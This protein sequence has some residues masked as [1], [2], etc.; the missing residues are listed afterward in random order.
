MCK[1]FICGVMNFAIYECDDLYS[2]VMS[3][4]YCLGRRLLVAVVL[5]EVYVV[6]ACR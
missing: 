1:S 4:N 6:T 5:V 2:R 3:E